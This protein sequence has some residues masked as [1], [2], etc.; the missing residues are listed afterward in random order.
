ME[1]FIARGYSRFIMPAMAAGRR[2][3]RLQRAPFDDAMYRVVNLS[4]LFIKSN[5]TVRWQVNAESMDKRMI[6]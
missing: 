2:I 1:A 3:L 6:R 5:E 4:V